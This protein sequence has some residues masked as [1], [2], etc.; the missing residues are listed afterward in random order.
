[1]TAHSS[2]PT[3][4]IKGFGLLSVF[5]LIIKLGV[6]EFLSQAGWRSTT[7]AIL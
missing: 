6:P 5:G 1:M 3:Q 7:K 2:Q 4:C